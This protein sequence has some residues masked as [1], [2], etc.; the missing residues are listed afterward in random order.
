MPPPGNPP[1]IPGLV[2][3]SK[4]DLIHLNHVLIELLI[5]LIFYRLYNAPVRPIFDPT[6]PPMS[7]PPPNYPN[8]RAPRT[9]EY[10]SRGVR[11][12]TPPG[13]VLF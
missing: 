12:R 13:C 8:Y 1:F 11:G 7:G 2:I 3:L 10:S 5:K 4:H 9:R 6:R